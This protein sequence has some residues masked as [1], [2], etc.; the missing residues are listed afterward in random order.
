MTAFSFTGQEI[1]YDHYFSQAIDHSIFDVPPFGPVSEGSYSYCITS[2]IDG[3][4]EADAC[5][6]LSSLLDSTPPEFASA[7]AV[8]PDTTVSPGTDVTLTF[9]VVDDAILNLLTTDVNGDYYQTTGLKTSGYKV[10]PSLGV[11][12]SVTV[13]YAIPSKGK[14]EPYIFDLL[15]CDLTGK[16][17][18]EST[19][20]NVV[21]DGVDG[22]GDDDC[23]GTCTGCPQAN[24]KFDSTCNWVGKNVKECFDV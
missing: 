16:C 6:T 14:I 20:V 1:P 10:S 11:P 15:L 13:T 2:Y 4:A 21:K 22:G 12:K 8:S 19:T 18:Q 24:C 17:V 7:I 5:G 23:G 9:D 3:A